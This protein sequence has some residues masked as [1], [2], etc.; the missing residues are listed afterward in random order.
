MCEIQADRRLNCSQIAD[1]EMCNHSM[2]LGVICPAYSNACT[3]QQDRTTNGQSC[4]IFNCDTNCSLPTEGNQP[5]TLVTMPASRR[6][7]TSSATSSMTRHFE[8]TTT[9][10]DEQVGSTFNEQMGC[11]SERALGGVVGVLVTVLV[12]LII[13]WSISCVALVKRSSHT[14][15]Q[16]KY[17]PVCLFSHVGKNDTTIVFINICTQIHN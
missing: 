10:K 6:L 12:I 13:G 16:I 2:D 4:P 3:D 8:A 11:T 15:K 7:P 1:S 9:E 5:S 17:V 14:Q